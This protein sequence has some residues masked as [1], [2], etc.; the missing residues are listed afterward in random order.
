MSDKNLVVGIDIG[1]TKTAFGFVDRSNKII[2]A[3]SIETRSKD[4]AEKFLTR[5]YHAIEEA[6][7]GLPSHHHLCGI[8]IG[9]PNANYYRGTIE[10]AV[11]LNWGKTVH[12]VELM[13]HYYNMPIALTNDANVAALGEM[14]FDNARGMK[15]FMVITLGTGL[16][17]GIVVDGRL[18]YGNSG[19]AR[20]FGHTVVDP[21][22]RQCLCGKKGC[23]E[24]YASATGLVKGFSQP[25]PV[26]APVTKATAMPPMIS[27]FIFHAPS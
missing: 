18:L 23:L 17:S 14:L 6:R 3:M 16:G 2:H 21:E 26:K 9:T 10:Q 25:A 27:L 4:S 20:E 5:L 8:G 13:R 1:G 19:F 12:L 7:N 11:H 15:N 22:G 24:T